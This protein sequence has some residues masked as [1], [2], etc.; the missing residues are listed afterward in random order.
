ME[1]DLIMTLINLFSYSS[2]VNELMEGSIILILVINELSEATLHY[3]I[4]SIIT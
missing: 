4:E 2:K 1:L 3:V